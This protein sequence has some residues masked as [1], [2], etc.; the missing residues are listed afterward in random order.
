M[1]RR[2]PG[3]LA[4]GLLASVLLL[5][6]AVETVRQRAYPRLEEGIEPIHKVAVAPFATS[7]DLAQAER[8]AAIEASVSVGAAWAGLL[9]L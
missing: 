5:G 9:S 4:A 3:P 1:M 7:A 6:C 8:R 2:A